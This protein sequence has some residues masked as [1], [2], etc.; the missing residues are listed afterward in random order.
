MSALRYHCIWLGAAIF[1]LF[2]LGVSGITATPLVV[3][4]VGL[5]G[6]GIIA[7]FIEARMFLHKTKRRTTIRECFKFA[8]WCA[9][10]A[11]P[12]SFVTFLVVL[13]TDFVFAKLAPPVSVP[14]YN[15]WVLMDFFPRI[16]HLISIPVVFGLT[17]VLS[18]AWSSILRAPTNDTASIA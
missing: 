17:L 8:F 6:A 4:A 14:F 10:L 5:V 9:V 16:T 7:T 11:L 2:V 1:L 12:A 13:W 15:F 18:I 3:L